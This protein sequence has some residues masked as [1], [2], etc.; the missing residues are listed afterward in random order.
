MQFEITDRPREEDEAFIIAQTR[1]Y[2]SAFTEKDVRSLCVFVRDES[3]SIVGGLTGKTHWRYL[4]IAF[5]WVSATHRGQDLGSKLVD[6]AEKEARARGCERALLNTFSFQALEFYKKRG[7]TEFGRLDGFS[8]KHA[9]HY[10][11]KQLG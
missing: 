7:Y 2:N 1:E 9:R 11:F 3:G 10:L 4:D 5:L 8:G 6:A